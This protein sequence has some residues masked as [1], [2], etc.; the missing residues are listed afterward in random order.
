MTRFVWPILF[1]VAVILG[2]WV[3]ERRCEDPSLARK[4]WLLGV[5]GGILGARIWY[6]AQYGLGSSGM[7]SWGFATGAVL[8]V[9]LYQRLRY[10]RWQWGDLLDALVPGILLSAALVKVGCFVHGCCYGKPSDLPWAVTYPPGSPAYEGQ[11]SQGL[12]MPFARSTLPIHP[13]QLYDAL[14]AVALLVAILLGGRRLRL[15]RHGLLLLMAA[16][17]SAFRFLLEFVRDDSG[18]RHVGPLTFAQASYLFLLLA[19]LA[20]MS[21]RVRVEQAANRVG[22]SLLGNS[23]PDSRLTR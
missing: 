10:G 1:G 17:Y 14:F 22:A 21:W 3:T 8:A 4:T 18:G 6:S 12:I 5:I 15:P 19:A 7:S 23:W 2:T 11:L 20:V 9:L 16:L 13:T